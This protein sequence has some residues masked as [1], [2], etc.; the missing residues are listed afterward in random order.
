MKKKALFFNWEALMMN[1]NG[2]LDGEMELASVDWFL[3]WGQ[4][5]LFLFLAMIRG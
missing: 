4:T 3:K 2:L 1:G 5:C